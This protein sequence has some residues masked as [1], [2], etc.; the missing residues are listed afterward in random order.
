VKKKKLSSSVVCLIVF[1]ASAK[2]SSGILSGN[3]NNYGDVDECLSI[4]QPVH[5]IQGKHCGVRFQ[6]F[7][8]DPSSTPYIAFLQQLT[9]SFELMKSRLDD[10]R[11]LNDDAVPQLHFR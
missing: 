10:V 8:N 2:L 11:L 7:I 6:T 4:N 5:S 9:Q 3:V 1:D